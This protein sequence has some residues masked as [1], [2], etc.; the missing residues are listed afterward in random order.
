MTGNRISVSTTK[1]LH[2]PV[3]VEINGTAY[4]V[5]INKRV[6]EQIAK[7]EKNLK[8]I[9]TEGDTAPAFDSIFLL[10]DEVELMTGAP[11]E[12]IEQIDFQDLRAII[13]F[14][15]LK[16]YGKAALIPKPP[17][18]ETKPEAKPV[19]PEQAEKNGLE[20]GANPLL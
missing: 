7:I 14:V 3:E 8:A 15:M 4:V 5:R 17:D 6:F 20:A 2:T 13:E 1:T 18:A 9:K 16:Y 19:S 11:R 10:Y 12:E